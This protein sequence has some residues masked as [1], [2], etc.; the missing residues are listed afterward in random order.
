MRSLALCLYLFIQASTLLTPVHAIKIDIVRRPSHSRP[1]TRLARR[2]YDKR[3]GITGESVNT[4][5]GSVPVANTQ[6]AEY[7]ANINLGGKTI[8][9]VIDTGR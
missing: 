7:I 3:A 6:N 5:N 2:L 4:S 9:V 1:N 8:P